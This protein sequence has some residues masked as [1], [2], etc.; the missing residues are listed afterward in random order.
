[1]SMLPSIVSLNHMFANTTPENVAYL[2]IML[3]WYTRRRD[4]LHLSMDVFASE[5]SDYQYAQRPIH[6]AALSKKKKRKKTIYITRPYL[7]YYYT[8][9]CTILIDLHVHIIKYL[10]YTREYSDNLSS[11]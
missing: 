3:R 8:W 10:I 4:S 6:L 2:L 1:M 5:R 9:R 7:R 11:A